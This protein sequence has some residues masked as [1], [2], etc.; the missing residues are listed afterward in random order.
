[1]NSY[2]GFFKHKYVQI[3]PKIAFYIIV[4]MDTATTSMEVLSLPRVDLCTIHSSLFK[5]IDLI[6]AI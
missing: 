4:W 6:I 2:R 5:S 3:N 1:M